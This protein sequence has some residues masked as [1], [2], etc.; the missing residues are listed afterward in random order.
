MRRDRTHAVC[1]ASYEAS[2]RLQCSVA[3]LIVRTGLLF[4]CYAAEA[5]CECF[6]TIPQQ[7]HCQF[8]ARIGA[9]GPRTCRL[10]SYEAS[11]RLQCSVATLIVRTGLLFVCYAAE[12]LC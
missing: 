2:G 10:H 12:A 6:L 4:V 1:I 5:L 8:R 7:W 11:G 3:T 9:S